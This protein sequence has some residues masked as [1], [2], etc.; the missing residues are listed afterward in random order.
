[1][2]SVLERPQ[3]NKIFLI[4][5]HLDDMFIS[6]NLQKNNFRPFLNGYLKNLGYEQIV[7]YS[8]AKNVGKF[9][10]DDES[11]IL[12]I[13]KNKGLRQ[14]S[15][16]D[17]EQKPAEKKRRRIMNPRA[18]VTTT[19]ASS[20]PE[21]PKPQDNN[22]TAQP[23]ND[24][25]DVKLTY[26]QPKITPVEFLDDAK[27][28]M[29]DTS[30]K[31][32]IVFTF[33]QD[34]FT[35]RSAPLQPYLELVSHLWDEYSHEAN[36]NICI[37]LAPQMS[38][39]DLS[40][41]F[42]NMENGFVL[43][44]RFF[45]DNGTIN[46]RSTIEVGLPNLDELG[47][48]LEYLRIIGDG[49]KKLSFKQEDKKD[50]TS[51]L[52][53]LSRE[54]DKDENRSGYLHAIYNNIVD[55][56]KKSEEYL[57]EF[58]EEDVKKIYSQYKKIDESDPFE[59]L[60]NTKGWESV[61]TRIEEIL[62]DY[63]MKKAAAEEKSG[64]GK[65]NKA[66]KPAWA[67]ERIDPETENTGY[68]YPVPHFIL[69]GNPGVGKT[70]V[71]RLIGQ[72]FYDEG[73][74]LKGNT[75]EAK[76]DDL[77]DQYVGG[78][79]IKTTECVERAQEGV[80]FI[81]DAYSLLEKGDVHNYPKEAIDT[82]VP[83]MTN[84]DKYRFCMIMAGYPE[85]M[86]ELLEMNS[87]L[88]SRFSKANI[89]TIEDYKPDLLQ[90]IFVSNCRKDGY[91]FIGDEEGET[92]LDLDLFFTNLYNQRNRA[93]FGNARDIVALAKEVKMQCS[94]RDDVLKCI[95]AEDFGDSQKY[96][97]KR[98]VS[99]IDEIYA[100]IDNYVGMGFVKDLFKNIRFEV[101]D[102][103]DSKKRGIK[104][105]EYPDHYIFAGNP[106]TGK[107]TVGKMIGEFY[108][109]MEV[110]GG[111]ETLFVDASDIIGN[112]V[113]DSKN[114]I[115]E[116][117]QKAI[118]HNQV[119]Y[120]DEAYQI[121]ESAYGNE[122]IGAMMT[123]MTENAND[124]K[125]IFGMYSNKVEEFLKMNA[126]LA[127]RLRVVNFPDYT[128]DQLLE[129]FDRTV[130]AQGCTIT[131]EAH[132][133]IRLIL[134]YKYNVRGEDFGNAGEVKKLVI[135]MKRLR[136]ERTYSSS[137]PDINKYEYTLDDI[138]ADMLAMVEDQ[139]NP[140]SLED[141]MEELNQQIGMSDLKDIIV[142]KQE[143]IIFAQK[144]GEG[145]ADIRPGYY[146]FVGNPGTGK[147]TSAKLF[148]ECLHQL[149]VVKTNNFHSC[150]AKDLIGLYVGETDKK[151]YALLQKSMNSVLF[152]DEAY[153]LSYADSHSDTN[154]K[155]EALEQIIAFMDEPEHRKKCCII[156][157]GYEKDMQGLYKSNSGMRS[158]I[159]EVHF[160][161]YTAKE[162]FDIFALFCRKNGYTITDGVE[163]I[164]IP[165]FEEL[166]K[167]EYFSNGRTA[168]TIFEKTTMNL[169]RRVVRS[170]NI[171]GE[172]AK[173][174]LPEDLLSLDE[175]VAVIGVDGK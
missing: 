43:K 165:I 3:L 137:D 70:T 107:T 131:D 129:I 35:D 105:E 100:Q 20:Q 84:P 21:P 74:L 11:A 160:R 136:L 64:K 134:T 88:R 36:E 133:R 119:L 151:T 69:R 73:I 101:L 53:Y 93:D 79:A 52:M 128:P 27:K 97:V 99:S 159:E 56:M 173:K 166:K 1:M 75:I 156:L 127:R 62:K 144:S 121:S 22:T 104:P 47:Y 175:A 164:Y 54:A 45:N 14:A 139:V 109:M 10:L 76:R 96:F 67:N 50:I 48:M 111:A 66:D 135:D 24:N 124:F 58:T 55:Y 29:A 71:A 26:K 123:K 13:N 169:K 5:G 163:E 59:K 108:H 8:G 147:S 49:G 63:R 174:I 95:I 19:E 30:H 34:F 158:R 118:D 154:Y 33:F 18:G 117:M 77:V 9:V 86:D 103:I 162:T 170:E 80:L 157:A 138:P 46:R 78:T 39:S 145:M 146:F 140:K 72:I 155:K 23:Q 40:K 87:G 61:A 153:S 112:H 12:A 98:G 89:L 2:G 17:A 44:N 143:E 7:F 65:K 25:K 150:T 83:I 126:G 16:S 141:I 161:D 68:R 28:M 130:K 41:M 114:K 90:E 148:A 37:F 4:Y 171:S 142:Q 149:G 94:L 60:K 122:I 125:V 81:D 120:I 32:A 82:L 172:D 15:S 116:V 51:S 42:D 57:V 106:G 85:P 110:L 152:I 102:T 113:G 38:N 91:R 92:P 132:D 6:R 115:V 168:R 167:L 31:S